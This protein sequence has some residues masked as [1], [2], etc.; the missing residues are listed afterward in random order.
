[1]AAIMPGRREGGGEI[2]DQNQENGG[3]GSYMYMYMYECG[4]QLDYLI[5]A[6]TI[7]HGFRTKSKN[8][9][10][11]TTRKGISVAA[12]W[13]TFQLCYNNGTLQRF[14]SKHVVG[15]SHCYSDAITNLARLINLTNTNTARF[16]VYI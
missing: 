4:K 9:N 14:S 1:M 12:E 15:L 8:C 11:D 3:R 5:E 13:H 7:F 16:L 2:F 6:R 10:S